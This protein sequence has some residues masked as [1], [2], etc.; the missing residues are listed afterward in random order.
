MIEYSGHLLEVPGG[1]VSDTYR[2]RAY[3]QV[4]EQMEPLLS[5]TSVGSIRSCTCLYNNVF[6]SP[7]SPLYET[8]VDIFS[9]SFANRALL[10]QPIFVA[11]IRSPK[12]PYF[13]ATT[14]LLAL[15]GSTFALP[16]AWETD[17]EKHVSLRPRSCPAN[18]INVVFNGGSNPSSQ[19]PLMTAASNWITF[20]PGT[21][22]SEI[23]MMAFASDV[24]TAVDI[25]NGPSPPEYMLTFNEPDYSYDNDTP[26]M[27]PQQAADAIEP[28]LQSPGTQT[29][30][31]AP[32]TAD[33]TSSWLTDFYTACNC[34][35]FFHAYNIHV[36][37]PDT[38]SAEA[39]INAFH[40]KF[41]DKPLWVTEIAPGNANPSCSLSWGTVSQF[42]QDIYSWGASQGWIER[43]FWNSGNEIPNDTNVCN[44]WLV[45]E[46]N[47]P[48]P[49]LATF[50]GLQC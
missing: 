17:S 22:T 33:P 38:G 37:Q 7:E 3:R 27:S 28:L 8:R 50:N 24:A 29:M 36:Y 31:I 44:S 11:P 43:I 41:S 49:L 20:S 46:N 14:L 34:Q 4:Q 40:A 5:D 9:S 48:S 23:P 16:T 13:E 25:V 1:D 47:N 30:F 21:A 19:Y 6:A 45:D 39:Q 32:V 2:L 18:F 42:M 15:L 12:M 35:G 10:H 26:T